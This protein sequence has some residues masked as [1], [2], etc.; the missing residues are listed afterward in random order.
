MPYEGKAKEVRNLEIPLDEQQ[1][2]D[3]ERAYQNGAAFRRLKVEKHLL[4]MIKRRE[5]PVVLVDHRM[6]GHP[7]DDR[8]RLDEALTINVMS[9]AIGF[10]DLGPGRAW[11]FQTDTLAVLAALDARRGWNTNRSANDWLLVERYLRA[12]FE[13]L[14]L[15]QTRD[16]YFKLAAAWYAAA[17]KREP[18]T[19]E[20]RA[21]TS[22]LYDEYAFSE[23]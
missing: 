11:D 7:L 6:Q 2:L 21:L 16:D 9:N 18:A 13:T 1:T 12:L 14:G 15:P 10:F 8:S 20:L 4:R 22:C 23:N 17:R 5:I 19:T 3:G